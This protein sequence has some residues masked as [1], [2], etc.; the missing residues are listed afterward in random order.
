MIAGLALLAALNSNH[1]AEKARRAA[2]KAEERIEAATRAGKRTEMLSE[3]ERKNAIVGRMLFVTARKL[4][5]LQQYPNLR[6]KFPGEYERLSNN[7]ALMQEFKEVEAYQREVAEQ[8][9]AGS[10]FL[11]Q[12][13]ALAD[14]KRLRLRLESEII[15]E[16]EILEGLLREVADSGA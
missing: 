12:E 9:D 10:D 5:I 7:V 13:K 1:I 8:A 2:A 15:K 4:L 14:V 6:D 16:S 11:L 3:I